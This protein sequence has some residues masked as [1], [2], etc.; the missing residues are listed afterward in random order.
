MMRQFIATLLAA[1]LA[2]S[3]P[4]SALPDYIPKPGGEY[5]GFIALDEPRADLPVGALWV[6]GHGPVGEGASADNLITMRSLTGVTIDRSLQLGLLSGILK[7][8]DISPSL[9]N[10]VSVR[11]N[12]LSVVRVKDMGQL[13]GPKGEPRIYEALKAETLTITTDNTLGLSA[14]DNI[15]R[16]YP[17]IERA[18]IGRQSTYTIDARQMFIAFRVVT[19]ITT[20][21]EER[22]VPVKWTG[23]GGT[24]SFGNWTIGIE[25]PAASAQ[26]DIPNK[27]NLPC[28]ALAQFKF[29]VWKIRP[30]NDPTET[31]AALVPMLEDGYA[32]L[33]LPIPI[34][35]RKGGLFD[36]MIVRIPQ[37]KGNE[38]QCLTALPKK[39]IVHFGGNRLQA[40]NS[41]KAP[42]W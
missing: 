27:E 18:D 13:S 10:R 6:E 20:Q 42:R 39:L 5:K 30:Q 35:D 11:F 2:I 32:K 17:I 33:T 36:R 23:Q 9:R 40:T 4:A 8:F 29:I 31:D 1:S 34:S 28:F 26:T 16:T 38:P 14:Q 7:L 15:Y 24:A 12:E 37:A 25:A 3:S 21:S 22:A 19:A 41:P